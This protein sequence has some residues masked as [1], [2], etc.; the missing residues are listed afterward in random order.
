MLD[1]L[2]G[3]GVA[4]LWLGA[5]GLNEIARLARDL[6]PYRL[7][8]ANSF[9][10]ALAT[11]VLAFLAFALTGGEGL[12]GDSPLVWAAG[13]AVAGALLAYPTLNADE[14]LARALARRSVARGRG[15][16]SQSWG[17]A[18]IAAV[19][20]N[21]ASKRVP[22][23]SRSGT[24]VKSSSSRPV[25]VVACIALFEEAIFRGGLLVLSLK[26]P[27]WWAIVLLIVGSALFLLNHRD[28]GYQQVVVKMPL[29]AACF[30]VTL[31]SGTLVGAVILHVIF[32]VAR[33][34]RIVRRE[35]SLARR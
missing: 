8:Q 25:L 34:L 13:S 9:S 18:R 7:T 23:P 21:G 4:A 30:A 24:G 16:A 5:A 35:A 14:R 27:I 20:P 19:S 29:L 15:T 1:A 33:Q 10:Y 11:G 2:Y 6:L 32:N 17:R 31:A 22:S 12:R 26:L 3:Y 28:L